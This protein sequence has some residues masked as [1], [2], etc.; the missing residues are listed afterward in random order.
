MGDLRE[1]LIYDWLGARDG[2][3]SQV[4]KLTENQLKWMPG[5]GGADRNPDRA[6]PRG[7][8][9]QPHRIRAQ[10]SAH[11]GRPAAGESRLA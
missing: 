8:R 10:R 6:A 4:E 3:I 7:R 1:G 9:E 5:P 2:V 11:A